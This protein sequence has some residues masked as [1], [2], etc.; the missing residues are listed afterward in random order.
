[1]TAELNPSGWALSPQQIRICP[2]LLCLIHWSVVERGG[3]C[4][5]LF[6]PQILCQRS[7][8]R[9]VTDKRSISFCWILYC[10]MM[11]WKEQHDIMCVYSW[12]KSLMTPPMFVQAVVPWALRLQTE[13]FQTL[14]N[15]AHLDFSPTTDQCQ[16]WWHFF[17]VTFHLLEVP[18]P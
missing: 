5:Y 16:L 9:V 12:G 3:W 6:V 11:F 1:M 18:N 2:P 7:S 10:F 14:P 15:H 13:H 4:C 17:Q 8:M